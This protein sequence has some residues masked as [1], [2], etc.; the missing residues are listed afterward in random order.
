MDLR[1]LRTMSGKESTLG[2]FYIDSKPECFTLEDEYRDKKVKGQT[3]I[4]KGR[5]E[6][7]FREVV[8]PLTKKYRDK[9]T[10]FTYH[11]EIIGVPNYNYVYIHIGNKDDHTDACLLLGDTLTNNQYEDGFLGKS[12]QAFER[13]YKKV[14][15]VLRK[16]Q[17]VFIDIDE[18]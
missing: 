17:R 1:A 6:V 4:P 18:I 9:F 14:S 11:L 8:S 12:T 16:G 7:K 15:S 10:W 5:Y 13:V 2:C 3:R